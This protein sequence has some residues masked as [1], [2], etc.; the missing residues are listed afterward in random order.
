MEKNISSNNV[1]FVDYDVGQDFFF[2]FFFLS[3]RI[4]VISGTTAI[5]TSSL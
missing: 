5:V 2:L 1:A 3:E 4:M